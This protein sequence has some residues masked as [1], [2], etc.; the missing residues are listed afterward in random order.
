[1]ID[2]PFMVMIPGRV[3]MDS[4]FGNDIVQMIIHAG[5]VVKLVLLIL[6]LFSVISWTIIF[7][8]YR[9]LRKAQAETVTFA[10]KKPP[11]G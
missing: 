7:M 8:K 10:M 4:A 5:P 1:M 3:S 11:L 2:F 6:F 9:L